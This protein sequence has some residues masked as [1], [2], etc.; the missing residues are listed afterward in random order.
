MRPGASAALGYG[1]MPTGVLVWLAVRAASAPGPFLSVPVAALGVSS[2]TPYNVLAGTC[3]PLIPS[4]PNPVPRA[5][6]DV[7]HANSAPAAVNL[8]HIPDRRHSTRAFFSSPPLQEGGRSAGHVKAPDVGLSNLSYAS[9]GTRVPG[10]VPGLEPRLYPEGH[11]MRKKTHRLENL[12]PSGEIPTSP[13]RKTTVWREPNGRGPS[14][15]G[16]GLAAVH[17]QC[18]NCCKTRAAAAAVRALQ[19]E[20]A[21]CNSPTAP[22][23]VTGRGLAAA[24]ELQQYNGCSSSG[25]SDVA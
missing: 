20:C 14:G 16:A 19:L 23:L 8:L 3:A 2:V 1:G 6:G 10:N 24:P 25:T 4:T 21:C 12:T 13:P 18:K 17:M 15:N 7:L 5:I 9:H 22:W 11:T